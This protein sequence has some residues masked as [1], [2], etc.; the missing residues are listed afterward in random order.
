MH[1]VTGL[2]VTESR[3]IVKKFLEE[4]YPDHEVESISIDPKADGYDVEAEMKE[5]F[6]PSKR[7][8]ATILVSISIIES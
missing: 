3:E 1:L 6:N 8:H 4:L 7:Y 2:S 5:R